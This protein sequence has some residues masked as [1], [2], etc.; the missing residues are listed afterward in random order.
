MRVVKLL[1]IGAYQVSYL[2]DP[3]NPVYLL[4]LTNHVWMFS[5]D[6]KDQLKELLHELAT[7]NPEIIK[8]GNE[9]V[10]LNKFVCMS[11]Y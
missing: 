5:V 4:D 3:A 1:G 8:P 2:K 7:L 10:W 9:W 11:A 6:S